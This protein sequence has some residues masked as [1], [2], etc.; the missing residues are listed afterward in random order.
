MIMEDLNLLDGRDRRVRRGHG[1]KRTI[2]T[3]PSV[4]DRLIG[5]IRHSPPNLISRVYGVFDSVDEPLSV[6]SLFNMNSTSARCL[7]MYS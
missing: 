1:P 5:Q 2:Q 4:L 6:E 7:L 3:R